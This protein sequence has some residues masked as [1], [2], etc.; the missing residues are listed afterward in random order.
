MKKGQWQIC[1]V[2]SKNGKE[3]GNSAKTVRKPGE[4][5]AEICSFILL[6]RPVLEMFKKWDLLITEGKHLREGRW[7][8]RAQLPVEH[9]CAQ[10]L[11]SEWGATQRGLSSAVLWFWEEGSLHSQ[12]C[13]VISYPWLASSEALFWV[14]KV[15]CHPWSSVFEWSLPLAVGLMASFC[16]CQGRSWPRWS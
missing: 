14:G 13:P 3:G 6:S 4:T 12:H 16:S 2:L 8:Y 1:A 15:R 9:S 10:S 5:D 11:G 7:V